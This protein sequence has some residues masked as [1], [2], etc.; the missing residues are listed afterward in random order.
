[1]NSISTLTWVLLILAV[2][3]IGGVLLFNFFQ[4]RKSSPKVKVVAA[5][6]TAVPVPAS[7]GTS[8]APASESLE[9]AIERDLTDAQ[10]HFVDNRI[11]QGSHAEPSI[12]VLTQY[13]GDET[14]SKVSH[15]IGASAE[16]HAST[17][18]VAQ[19][20]QVGTPLEAVPLSNVAKSVLSNE[21]DYLIEFALPSLQSG[22]RLLSMTA[23]HRRAGGKPVA[24][25]GLLSNGQWV[26]LQAGELYVALRAGLLLANRHGP[27]NAMEFS[28]F[29]NFAQE[30]AKQLDCE[31]TLAD[32]PR[33]LSR[34]RDVDRQC[35][36]LD[37]QLGI[38][39]HT[40][41]VISP[42]ML[43]SAA[44]EHGL[45]EK[46]GSRFAKLDD[47]G[48]TLFTV[49]FGE[50]G[51][52]L[53]MLL[54]VPRAPAQQRPWQQMVQCALSLAKTLDGQLVDDAGKPLPEGLWGQIEEQLRQRYWALEAAGIEPGSARALRLFN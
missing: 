20:P 15:A 47:K 36:E 41:T 33:V 46:G 53:A 19:S 52:K 45:T 2:V 14:D 32:M 37:A 13:H 24:F 50:Q 44:S 26:V 29:G 31:V 34:A 11:E 17:P 51:D 6:A 30:L 25:D 1:M 49:S 23:A 21:F 48:G 42:A 7:V 3:V 10:S 18:V 28:D 27:L 35:A 39:I 38:S 40:A 4:E 8:K 22:E 12:G 9:N 16:M 54:D 5:A 43:A